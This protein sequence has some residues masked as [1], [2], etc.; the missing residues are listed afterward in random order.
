M[1]SCGYFRP[2]LEMVVLECGCHS[3]RMDSTRFGAPSKV[4][5]LVGMRL[6]EPVAEVEEEKIQYRH[7]STA[8]EMRLSIVPDSQLMALEMALWGCTAAVVDMG[9]AK[10]VAMWAVFVGKKIHLDM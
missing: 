5:D 2:H 10:A 6:C 7:P 8:R 4:L 1:V 9:S 3:E